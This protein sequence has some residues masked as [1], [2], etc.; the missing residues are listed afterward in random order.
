MREVHQILFPGAEI[1]LP[2]LEGMPHD[3]VPAG[4]PVKGSGGSHAAIRPA[5]LVFYGNDL[6]LVGKTAVLYAAAVKYS[7]GFAFREKLVLPFPK[8]TGDAS[9]PPPRNDPSD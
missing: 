6:S 2:F 9:L 4:G 8:R 1:I 5:V 3:A 7:S